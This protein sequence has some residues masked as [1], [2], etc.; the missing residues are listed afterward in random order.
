MKIERGCNQDSPIPTAW[1][2]GGYKF[3]RCPLKILDRSIYSGIKAYNY[4]KLGIL[5][6]AGGWR[7]QS[8]KFIDLMGIIE[9]DIDNIRKDNHGRK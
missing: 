6:N 4:F 3:Q 5:P 8:S 1:E 2:I 7:E 9:R